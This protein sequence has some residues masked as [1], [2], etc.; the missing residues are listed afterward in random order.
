M[1]TPSDLIAHYSTRAFQ[2]R[3]SALAFVGA[4][5]GADVAWKESVKPGLLGTV[6]IAVVASLGELNR[7]YTYSYL[8]ACRAAAGSGSSKAQS[9]ADSW[10]AFQRMNEGPWTCKENDARTVRLR[11]IV[12]R[13]LLSWATYVPGLAAGIYLLCR[14]GF[15]WFG[16]LCTAVLL[17]WWIRLSSSTPDPTRF[18]GTNRAR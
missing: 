14:D 15:A 8:C 9:E 16:V 12:N 5:L 13:F 17:A 18:L 11:K 10:Q 2:T 3:I 1:A 7:R 6:L 4:V